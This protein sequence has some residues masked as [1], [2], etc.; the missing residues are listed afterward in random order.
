AW[1]YGYGRFDESKGQLEKFHP[2]PHFSGK[3]W[4]GSA[5]WPNGPLGWLQLTARG[6]HT[7]NKVEHA[8]V[9]R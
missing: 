8:A 2:L 4:D 1:S 9:R 6:G 3:A 7:G 5:A